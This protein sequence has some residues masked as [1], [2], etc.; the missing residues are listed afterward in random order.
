[1]IQL[2]S[3][4]AIELH[5]SKAW[6]YWSNKRLA[7]F[8]LH[9]ECLC[10]PF[11]KFHE[12]IS[13]TLDITIFTHQFGNKEIVDDLKSKLPEPSSDDLADMIPLNL[14]DIFL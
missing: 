14:I 11:D 1:M 13:K 3:D 9:Q 12:A 4:Q 10:I 2:T 5:D 8:Q 6:E 7:A